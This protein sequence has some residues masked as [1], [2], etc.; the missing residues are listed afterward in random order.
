MQKLTVTF[1]YG[2]DEE[3]RLRYRVTDDMPIGVML[4]KLIGFQFVID[5]SDPTTFRVMH[6][7]AELSDLTKTFEECSISD[8]DEIYLLPT[9]FDPVPPPRESDI[10]VKKQNRDK[11]HSKRRISDIDDIPKKEPVRKPSS[12]SYSQKRRRPEQGTYSA[13]TK[14]LAEGEHEKAPQAQAAEKSAG[15]PVPFKP[16][17]RNYHRSH[18]KKPSAPKTNA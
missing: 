1:I 18:S 4:E 9:V 2:N 7:G 16:K 5:S 11:P 3:R 13:Q 10:P 6:G 14:I 15:A 8:G 17:N 12:A